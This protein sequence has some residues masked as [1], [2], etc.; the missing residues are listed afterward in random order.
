MTTRAH[1]T[2]WPARVPHAIEP[3]ATALPDNLLVSARRA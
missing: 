2:F 1:H 3:P